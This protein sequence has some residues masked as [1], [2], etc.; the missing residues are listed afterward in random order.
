MRERVDFIW[1][2]KQGATESARNTNVSSASGHMKPA[3]LWGIKRKLEKK[4]YIEHAKHFLE[5]TQTE[6]YLEFQVLNPAVEIKQRKFEPLKPFFIRAAKERKHMFKDCMKV[7]GAI[8]R[9]NGKNHTPL[10]STLTEAV[11]FTLCEKFDKNNYSNLKHITRDCSECGV[12]KLALLPEELSE[13]TEDQV[14]RKCYEYM[15]TGK[16]MSNG[17]EEKNTLVTKK[18]SPKEL[19]TYFQGQEYPYHSLMA[20]WKKEQLDNHIEHLTLNEVVCVHDY[21]EGYSCRQQDGL[22]SKYFNVA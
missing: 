15:A 10:P 1:S 22:Q 3:D 21:L 17:Q 6:A 5:K 14:V 11:N 4:Q 13:D 9:K 16:L 19:F 18:S 20:K 7:R 2:E 12:A 8:C